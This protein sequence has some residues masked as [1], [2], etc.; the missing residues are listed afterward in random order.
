M[1]VF[2]NAPHFHRG[3][4]IVSIKIKHTGPHKETIDIR[5]SKVAK[6]SQ[7]IFSLNKEKNIYFVC[8]LTI[9]NEQSVYLTAGELLV[10]DFVQG[11]TA[12]GFEG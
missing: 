1:T 12:K 4:K 3:T 7:A 5:G 9:S 2:N 8:I 11:T 6:Y 10:K